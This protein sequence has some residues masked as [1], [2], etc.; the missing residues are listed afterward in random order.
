MRKLFQAL[1][2]PD[3]EPL[4]LVDD[5]QPEVPEHDI[6]LQQP[7]RADHD[8]DAPGRR[9]F[10]NRLGFLRGL[11]TREQGDARREGCEP[12]GKVVIML[13]REQRRRDQDGDLAIL[14]DGFECRAHRHFGFSVSH[15]SADEAVHR[16]RRFHV[17]LDV[18]DGPDLI[19]RFLVLEGRLKLVEHRTVLSIRRRVGRVRG[20]HRDRQV[21]AP[22]PRCLF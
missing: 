15:I 9:V 5:D 10:Q 22:S 16:L 7:V 3:A 11:K 1:L 2:V 21:H 6:L 18:L 12:F 14:F 8:I 17:A 19:G 20:W 13:M 4:F